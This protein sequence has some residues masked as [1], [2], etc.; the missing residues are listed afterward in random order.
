MTHEHPSASAT[1]MMLRSCFLKRMLV[2]CDSLFTVKIIPATWEER[3]GGYSFIGP[4][5]R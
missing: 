2:G 1:L 5:I 3:G 4:R